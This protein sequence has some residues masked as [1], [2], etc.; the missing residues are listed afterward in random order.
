MDTVGTKI[1]KNEGWV[2]QLWYDNFINFSNKYRNIMVVSSVRYC[3][4]V[5]WTSHLL[6]G[7]R[8]ILFN[9]SPYLRGGGRLVLKPGSPGGGPGGRPP[10]LLVTIGAPR[11]GNP[12]GRNMMFPANLAISIGYKQC[13][14]LKKKIINKNNAK[15]TKKFNQYN[16]N[17]DFLN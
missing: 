16:E 14:R 5:H 2:F 15:I 10:P 8:Q 13:F 9:W 6:Q 3:T 11:P 12:G 17:I 4:R 1:K 7:T